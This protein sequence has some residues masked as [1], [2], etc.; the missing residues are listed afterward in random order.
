M[1]SEQNPKKKIVIYIALFDALVAL[2]AMAYVLIEPIQAYDN[3]AAGVYGFEPAMRDAMMTSRLNEASIPLFIATLLS[4]P[5]IFMATFFGAG[6]KI[7]LV[8][9]GIGGIA[10]LCAI[11]VWAVYGDGI[12][13]A[14]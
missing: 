6:E 3:L 2:C 10:L 14:M 13:T 4:A 1:M 11:Y 12:V 7:A 8:T 5:S 9:R